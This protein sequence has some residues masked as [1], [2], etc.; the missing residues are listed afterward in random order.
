[1]IETEKDLEKKL[2]AEVERLGGWAIKLL[3]F[4]VSGLPDRL[5]LF[6]K[7]R[8]AFVEV[9]GTGETP[10]KIQKFIHRRLEKIG[11]KVWIVDSSAVINELINTFRNDNS[12]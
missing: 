12:R 10:T 3:P 2:A 1:M 5:C 8:V 6:P 4:L 11:F 7:G 9:K